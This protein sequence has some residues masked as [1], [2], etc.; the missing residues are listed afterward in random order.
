MRACL[1]FKIMHYRSTPVQ[2]FN[3]SPH[4]TDGCA[5]RNC[6]LQKRSSCRMPLSK[7][8]NKPSIDLNGTMIESKT[9]NRS[10]LLIP[11]DIGRA[12]P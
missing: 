7:K 6:E 4:F 1:K 5:T 12:L 2:V 8:V 3:M 11:A 10:N 9:E